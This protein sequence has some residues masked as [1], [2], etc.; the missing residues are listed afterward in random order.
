MIREFESQICRSATNGILGNAPFNPSGLQ[1]CH[2]VILT[3]AS[4]AA[5][6]HERESTAVVFIL[7]QTRERSVLLL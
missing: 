2:A 4:K 1:E 6:I 5:D 3:P 7:L